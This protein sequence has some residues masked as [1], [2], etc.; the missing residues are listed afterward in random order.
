MLSSAECACDPHRET[1]V[2]SPL[3][4]NMPDQSFPPIEGELGQPHTHQ[5]VG[6]VTNS[7]LMGMATLKGEAQEEA[8]STCP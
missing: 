4:S 5:M 7:H 2:P 3:R 1:S 8:N 6:W